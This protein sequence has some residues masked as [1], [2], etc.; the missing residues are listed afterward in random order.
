[1]GKGLLDPKVD[2]VFKNIFGSEKNPQILI[3][4]LNATLK[5]VEKISKVEIKGVDIEKHFIEDK[6]SRLDIKAITDKNEIINVEIQ[7][8]NEHNM[9][10]RSM[11]YL[12]KMYEEQLAEGEDYSKLERTVCI[13]ILNFKYLKTDKFHTGYR[14]KEIES[15]EELTDIIEMHFIEIPKLK[16]DSDEKDMLVA[17]TEFLK[18]PESEKV[19]NLEMSIKE[20]REA[21]DE[22][23]KMS[24]NSKQREIYE[25]RAKILKDKVSALNKAREEGIEQGIKEGQ[26]KEK[27]NIAKK[28]LDILDNETIAIKTGLTIDKIQKLR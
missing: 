24:N 23:I 26:Y 12:S 15:N 2:F 21:K 11:Y 1:M 5:P 16:D 10:K 17:W 25:M 18:D 20:I 22:L 6:Y 13:N 3:S 4:F 8:K 14:L 28:L 27:I 7:L 9:I 19:R